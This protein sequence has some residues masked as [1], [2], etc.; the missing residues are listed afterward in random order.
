MVFARQGDVLAIDCECVCE[1]RSCF[2]CTIIYLVQPFFLFKKIGCLFI[3]LFVYLF[4]FFES[5]LKAKNRVC[6]SRRC[7]C[8]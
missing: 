6:T 7:S 5:A 8:H 2:I 4:V 1:D 3:F